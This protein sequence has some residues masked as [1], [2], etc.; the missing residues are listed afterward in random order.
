M[1]L[2]GASLE[3]AAVVAER[4][5]VTVQDT[6]LEP[7]GAVT[8]SLGVARGDGEAGSEPV[9]TL[10]EADRALYRAKQEGRNRVVVA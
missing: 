9:E 2:P 3:V 5:R 8:I 1:L 10:S 7:V 6:P 4:L